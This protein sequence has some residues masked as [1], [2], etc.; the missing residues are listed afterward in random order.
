MEILARRVEIC[1]GIASGKTTL[2]S[3]LNGCG[4]DAVFEDFRANPFWEAFYADPASYAFETEV[5]FL[6]Q[7][8]HGVK[9]TAESSRL[10]VCDF[11]FVLDRAYVDVTLRDAKRRTFLTVFDEVHR[12]LGKPGLLLH[13][14]C[15][16]E[17]ELARIRQR[18]RATERS[19]SIEYLDSLN[20][21]VER[22]ANAAAATVRTLCIDSDR[23]N[24]ATDELTRRDVAKMVRAE[25][26]SLG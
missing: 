16:A 12:E 19:I 22:Y 2:A 10:F 26:C 1:G 15:S 9:K 20:D 17:T 3:V 21:A 14:R 25:F 24:F 5:T 7:H 11:S 4:F 8:Y 13:L 23:Q 6:L 18:A